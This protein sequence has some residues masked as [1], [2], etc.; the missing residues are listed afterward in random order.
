M[1]LDLINILVERRNAELECLGIPP[2]LYHVIKNYLNKAFK[3]H[4]SKINTEVTLLRHHFDQ[5]I[6]L[7]LDDCFKEFYKTDHIKNMCGM[8][9]I[10]PGLKEKIIYEWSR[11]IRVAQGMIKNTS[12]YYK[13]MTIPSESL[14]KENVNE[15]GF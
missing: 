2:T 10:T 6:L 7:T 4:Q 11:D 3:P 12:K 14:E 13:F 8:F 9:N 1:N 15:Y 5:K